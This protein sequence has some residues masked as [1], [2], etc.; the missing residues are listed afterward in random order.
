MMNIFTTQP[1]A[2]FK[3][4][5]YSPTLLMAMPLLFALSIGIDADTRA[6]NLQ[7]IADASGEIQTFSSSGSLDL[8]SAFFKTLGTN[9]RSCAS[10]HQPA[11]GWTVTPEHIQARFEVDGGL[12][13]IFRPNDGANCPTDDVSTTEARR[14]AYSL[15][16]NKGLIRV[17]LPIPS[18]AE[19]TLA[20]VSDP[21]A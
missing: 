21:Y 16:L 2:T 1:R 12:D 15:L 10:C 20:G 3:L 18:S 4:R 19:F 6:P 17:S 11:D 7:S 13:P 5:R 9:A 14:S 8:N